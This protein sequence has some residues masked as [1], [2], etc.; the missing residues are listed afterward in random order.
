M[1]NL[2]FKCVSELDDPLHEYLRSRQGDLSME[3]TPVDAKIASSLS[4]QASSLVSTTMLFRKA[5]EDTILSVSPL[6]RQGLP[7]LE[8][9]IGR[10]S[11]LRK[12]LPDQVFP[13]F[14]SRTTKKKR[15]KKG[16][17]RQNFTN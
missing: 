5:M 15:K 14:Y 16:K 8:T 1:S 10:H 4:M 11:P 7:F 13:A 2:H 17:I 3:S 12:Y 6:V 9:E